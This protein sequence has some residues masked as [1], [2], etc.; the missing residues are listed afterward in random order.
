M[1]FADFEE[2]KNLSKTLLYVHG[3]GGSA[4][5][6]ERYK[7]LCPNYEVIGAEYDGSFPTAAQVGITDAFRKAHGEVTLLAESIGAYF[8]MLALQKESIKKA[9]LISPI[10]DM[11]KLILDMMSWANVS[12]ETLRKEGEIPTEFGETLSWKYLC[13]VREHSVNWNVPTCILYAD[14]DNLTSMQTVNSFAAA[15]DASVT[16][17]KNG[18]HW[19]HTEEQLKFLDKWFLSSINDIAVI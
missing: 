13:Y 6:A 1:T 12:E 14:K 10:L 7:L 15:H 2:V 17:M 8:S 5:G 4:E 3:K 16:V 9:L 18:E 11:E 19:F